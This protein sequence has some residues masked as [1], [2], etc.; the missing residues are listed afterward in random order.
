[1]RRI[2]GVLVI[3]LVARVALSGRGREVVVQMAGGALQSCVRACQRITRVL[4]V[5]ELRAD[6]VIHRV[7]LCAVGWEVERHVVND[8]RQKVLLVARVTC[9]R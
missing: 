3:R 7:A 2:V 4:Q 1:V 9:G 5:I 8:G 6:E